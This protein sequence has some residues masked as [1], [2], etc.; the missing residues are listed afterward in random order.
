ML[1]V[2][3]RAFYPLPYPHPRSRMLPFTD[4]LPSAEFPQIPR[5][6]RYLHKGWVQVLGRGFVWRSPVGSK[7]KPQ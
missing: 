5:D 3:L 1:R 7:A 6:F 4:S 2:R